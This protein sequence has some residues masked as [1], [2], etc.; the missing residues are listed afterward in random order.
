MAGLLALPVR[1]DRSPEPAELSSAGA[2]G[3]A[4]APS[5]LLANC[6]MSLPAWSFRTHAAVAVPFGAIVTTGPPCTVS[7]NALAQSGL[8]AVQPPAPAVS[9]VPQT[10][11]LMKFASYRVNA[12]AASPDGSIARTGELGDVKLPW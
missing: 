8:A 6:T 4:L 1:S 12:S 3:H 5:D 2:C 9:V 7:L 11:L 10:M